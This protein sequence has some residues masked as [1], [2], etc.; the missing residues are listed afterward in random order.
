MR[1]LILAALAAS[2]VAAPAFAQRQDAPFNGPR[3]EAVIGY[4]VID[5]RDAKE[6]YDGLLYGGAIGYD[7]QRG[8]LVFGVEGEVTGST[9]EATAS[10]VLTAGDTLRS[11]AGRD[12]Y[13]GVRVG[14]AT[15]NLLVYAKGGYSNARIDSSYTL[16]A[17][18]L[19]DGENLDGYR[20]GA[21]VEYRLGGNLYVKGEYRFSHYGEG[22]NFDVNVNRH[23]LLGGVGMRF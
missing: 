22:D 9:V 15:G 12:L 3:A 5:D 23:Q 4:D 6:S 11:G 21:G 20:L 2:T 17:T 10:N 19:E 18:T 1:T 16:G 8:S 7:M 14:A 13:A